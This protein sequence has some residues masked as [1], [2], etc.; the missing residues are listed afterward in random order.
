MDV[1]PDSAGSNGSC[2][3]GNLGCEIG[4]PRDKEASNYIIMTEVN[5][6]SD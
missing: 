1:G 3:T 4:E 6:L 5:Q 2:Q